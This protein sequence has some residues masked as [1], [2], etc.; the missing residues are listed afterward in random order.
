MRG[1]ASDR[2]EQLR[3]RGTVP[4]E[5]HL[6][7]LTTRDEELAQ[8]ESLGRRGVLV[9]TSKIPARARARADVRPAAIHAPASSPPQVVLV[10]AQHVAGHY[11]EVLQVA[12]NARIDTLS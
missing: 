3:V 5:E 11:D 4:V 6:E 10:L 7:L 8:G 2:A 1:S 12:L 9:H